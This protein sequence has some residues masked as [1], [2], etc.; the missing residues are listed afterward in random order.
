MKSLC[1]FSLLVFSTFSSAFELVRIPEIEKVELNRQFSLDTKPLIDA[2]GSGDIVGNGGGLLEQNFILAYYSLQSAIEDCLTTYFC[3]KNLQ[4][5]N[6]L[7]EIRTLFIQKLEQKNSL[8]FLSNSDTDNFFND[9][10]D[11]SARLA[12]TGFSIK[13][14]IF[15]NIDEA[16]AIQ[17]DI[18]A[19]IS[20]LIHELGHQVGI[21]SHS[22]LDQLSVKVRKNWE[23]NWT[24]S[25]IDIEDRVLTTRLFST[26]NNF[27]SAKF[28][29]VF[30]GKARN[31][32]SKIYDVLKCNAGETLYGF[33][34]SNAHW[35]RPISNRRD[36]SVTMDLWLDL[37]CEDHH[38]SIWTSQK[39]LSIEFEFNKAQGRVTDLKEVKVKIK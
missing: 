35:N 37:Y 11:R 25:S 34:L 33:Y 28:S 32:N 36:Y 26:K 18:P 24:E 31:L 30:E 12:K 1:F 2:F 17:N 27:I 16:I 13:H 39:D 3:Y 15:I 22:Y 8:I 9:E 5:K 10:F 38:G 4:D 21:A 29:Y 23:A 19:M 6:V 14:P 7:K 20:I